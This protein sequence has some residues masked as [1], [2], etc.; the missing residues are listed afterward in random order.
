VQHRRRWAALAGAAIVAALWTA[1]PPVLAQEPGATEHPIP[2][3]PPGA[4]ATRPPGPWVDPPPPPEGCVP[5]VEPNDRPEQAGVSV[6]PTEFCVAGTLELTSDQ[7][8][9]FW[10][11]PPSDGLTTWDV[12]VRGVPTTYTSVHIFELRSDVGVTPIE[13][14]GGGEVARVDSDVWIGTPVPTTGIR[15]APGPYLLGISRASSGFN[16]DMTDDLSYWVDLRRAESALPPTGDSE[17]NDAMDTAIPVAGEFSLSGDA[18][19]GR[20]M[21]RWQV[22]ADGDVRAWRIAAQASVGSS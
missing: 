21:Y 14:G 17:P 1:V 20:D 22:P 15:L 19:D 7:D 9:H 12:S 4:T 16:Q 10:E 13:R 3:T 11:V 2:T 6:L 8:L 5:E 18:G